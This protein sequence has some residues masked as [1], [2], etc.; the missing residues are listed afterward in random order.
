MRLKWQ[1]PSKKRGEWI[2]DQK[3]Q[4]QMMSSSKWIQMMTSFDF[5]LVFFLLFFLDCFKVCKNNPVCVSPEWS[6]AVQK[7]RKSCFMKH[8]HKHGGS[9][10]LQMKNDD[11]DMCYHLD[12]DSLRC[13]R[14]SWW[15]AVAFMLFI[16]QWV[17]GWC[18]IYKVTSIK[19]KM[20]QWKSSSFKFDDTNKKLCLLL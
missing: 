13:P 5:H 4:H 7:C 2:L 11:R 3:P 19:N 1:K 20:R 17:W 12:H 9:Y 14:G 16:P 8:T 18:S 6:G 15:P 10:F